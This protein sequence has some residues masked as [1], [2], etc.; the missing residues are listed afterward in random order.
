[1][2]SVFTLLTVAI[3]TLGAQAQDDAKLRRDPGYS[4]QNYKHA[5]KAAAARRWEGKSGVSVQAPTPQTAQAANYKNSVPGQA[6]AGGVTVPHRRNEALANRNYK[7]QQPAVQSAENGS[8]ARKRAKKT[9][10]D[11]A[12]GN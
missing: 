11:S 9:A 10:G 6:P 2:K 12:V 5:N 8:M 3:A 4:T 7:M 1:M